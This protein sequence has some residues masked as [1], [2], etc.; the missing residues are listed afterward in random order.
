MS[1][2]AA[3]IWSQH[4]NTTRTIITGRWGPDVQSKYPQQHRGTVGVVHFAWQQQQNLW[5]MYR[6][7]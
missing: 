1:V 3:D 5:N 6:K 7:A 2:S 4:H